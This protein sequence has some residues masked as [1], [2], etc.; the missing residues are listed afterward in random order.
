MHVLSLIAFAF[1]G[2]ASAAVLPRA[3]C[4]GATYFMTNRAA[5]TVFVSSINVDGSLSFIKEVPT[6]GKGSPVNSSDP[7]FSQH[8]VIQHDGVSLVNIES[9][10]SCCL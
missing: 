7:L 5:N 10:F 4:L 8:G 3:E 2:F 1:F 6:G 9:N